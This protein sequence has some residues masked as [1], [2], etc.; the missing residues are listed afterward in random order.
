[1]QQ[2][3]LFSAISL[4]T[5][6]LRTDR[7]ERAHSAEIIG[8]FVTAHSREIDARTLSDSTERTAASPVFPRDTTP[9]YTPRPPYT[10]LFGEVEQAEHGM[11]HEPID[12]QH[13]HNI[14]DT[15]RNADA[16]ETPE[17]THRNRRRKTTR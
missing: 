14:R 11:R 15:H 9:Y 5:I 2:F 3:Q 4:P 7:L 16:E 1:M 17:R 8:S 6:L 12:A 13:H 10:A